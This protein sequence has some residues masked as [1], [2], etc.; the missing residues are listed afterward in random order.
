[1][2][3]TYL[4]CRS[5][6][7]NG[8]Q[9]Y[10]QT[11][12]NLSPEASYNLHHEYYRSYG[13]AILGLVKH[14]QIDAMDFNTKVDDALPLEDILTK[15]TKLRKLFEDI[16]RS[17][18]KLWLF[19]N[20]YQTHGWRVVK[21]LGVDDLFEG[22]TFCDYRQQNMIAKPHKEMFEKA[23]REAGVENKE[24]CYFVGK[25]DITDLMSA[26]NNRRLVYQYGRGHGI[27]LERSCTFCRTSR[28]TTKDC[29]IKA[30]DTRFGRAKEC[31][32]R[33]F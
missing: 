11:H 7:L 8:A 26:N 14:H 29:S 30:P 27:W 1:M 13:L 24:D 25:S 12:L 16:D 10:F 18:V 2:Y 5:L 22:I 31:I 9:K 4:P 15:D 33:V 3:G 19:T 32:P 28:Q 23:M 17:K 21:F 20:A 6:Y